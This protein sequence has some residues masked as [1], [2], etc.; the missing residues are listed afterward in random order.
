MT[1]KKQVWKNLPDQTTPLSA[2]RLNHL[3]TQ[4]EKAVAYV[5]SQGAAAAVDMLPGVKYP[6]YIAH[7]GNRFIYPEHSLEAYEGTFAAGYTPEADV[8]VLADGTLVCVHDAT[9]ARTM[10][11]P[12]MAISAMTITDWQ[13]KRVLPPKN[14][15]LVGTGTG[16]PVLF[17][18]YLDRY[19]GRVMLWPE[20]KDPAATQ[21]I[22]DAVKARGLEKSVVLSSFDWAVVDQVVEAGIYATKAGTP[23]ITPSEYLARG[24]IGAVFNSANTSNATITSFKDAG[25]R[26]FTYTINTP[27]AAVADFARGVDG[28]YSDDTQAVDPNATNVLQVGFEGG[29]LA[30]GLSATV[31]DP[32]QANPKSSLGHL[33][34][35]G[36]SGSSRT[37]VRL[38]SFGVGASTGTVEFSAA[39]VPSPRGTDSSS[40]V[41]GVYMGFQNEGDG[42]LTEQGT[43]A[44]RLMILRASGQ[45][46]IFRFATPGAAAERLDAQLFPSPVVDATGVSPSYRLRV[47]FNSSAVDVT[48][49]NSG[50]HVSIPSTSIPGENHYISL[51]N[52]R[53]TTDFSNITFAR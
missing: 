5:D 37:S 42:P 27:S 24:V 15:I 19:G 17:E 18:D 53:M 39:V 30:P 25:L 16:T 20:I 29:F 50:K 10:T 38:G 44:C 23:D 48:E 8:R 21:G 22:I 43:F 14:G 45:V 31:Q 7:R 4:Y 9:T 28:V 12:N 41:A 2:S 40:W 26:V 32:A 13:A 52:N 1:Y 46:S 36:T 35:S 11:G 51:A 3:E 34:L 33:R 6:L 47:A 49:L